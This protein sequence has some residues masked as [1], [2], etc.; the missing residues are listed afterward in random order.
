MASAD[1]GSRPASSNVRGAEYPLIHQD[2]RVTFRLNAPDAQRVQVQPSGA[3]NGLGNGAFDMERDEDGV[4]TV[5]T[6]PALPGFHY[7]SLLVDGVAVNDPGSETYFG[8]GQQSSGIEIPEEKADYYQPQDV[9][10]GD[11]RA[12]WYLSE[13]TGLWRR[14]HVYTP[15]VYDDW[16]SGHFPVLYLQHG[17]GEDERGWI[18]QGRANFI[19]DNLIDAKLARPMIVV[20]DCGYTNSEELVR[21]PSIP[22]EERIGDM[23]EGFGQVVLHE[24]VPM[25]DSTYRTI[26]NRENRA[27][28]G[29]ARGGAQALWIGLKHLDYFGTIAALSGVLPGL[30]LLSLGA[31]AF[32]D[33]ALFNLRVPVFWLGAGTLETRFHDTLMA[34]HQALDEAGIHH[35]LFE[36]DGTAHEWQTWRRSLFDLASRL[37]KLS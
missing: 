37:F 21:D 9:P 2:L 15:P 32:A 29:L 28:A 31:D 22:V 23:A 27:I 10:H 4:W 6:P 35:I 26:A 16:T 5:T 14:A 11:V 19:L 7:Y 13:S 20:M 25:I 12:R 34:T 17:A 8:Y 36:S 24:L 3:E 18:E 30:D 1:E 33:A